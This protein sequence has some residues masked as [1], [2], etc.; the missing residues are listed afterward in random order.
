MTS[1]KTFPIGGIHPE[2]HKITTNKEIID[3]GLP[4]VVYIPVKQHIGSPAKIIVQKGDKV[5]VGTLL[6]DAD[7][8]VSADVFSSVSGEVIKVEEVEGEFGYL[9]SM[10]TIQVAGDEFEPT[11]DRSP[12]LV[13]DIILEP[14]QI[15]DKIRAAGIVGMGGAGYPTPVKTAVPSDKKIDTLIL[16]GIECEP[17]LTADDR[18]MVEKAEEIIVGAKIINKV[19]G[20]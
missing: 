5:K 14:Q 17:W 6:A 13:K 11:I 10:I 2:K 3:A 8:I 20:I 18:L 12:D 1:K 4:E 7:G 19:L 16:N 15:V 9:E